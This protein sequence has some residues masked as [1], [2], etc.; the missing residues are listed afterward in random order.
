MRLLNK[1]RHSVSQHGPARTAQTAMSVFADHWFDW[2]Y[3]TDTIGIAHLEDLRVPQA[4]LGAV[5]YQPS[6]T[7]YFRRL[8]KRAAAPPGSVF[9]DLGAG[10]CRTLLIAAQHG[11]R[12]AV[13]VEFSEELCTTARQNIQIFRRKT[14]L[15]TQFQVIRA[16]VTEY[17]I[18]NEDNVLYISAFAEPTLRRILNNVVISVTRAPRRLTLISHNPYC[19][20]I[21]ESYAGFTKI[22]HFVFGSESATLFEYQPT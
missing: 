12:R 20:G 10:K 9:V 13:G 16:D 17:R 1:V 3:G 15:P 21:I 5:D 8:L 7:L 6:R 14:A 2:C 11:Y 4:K 22:A 19:P 18:G